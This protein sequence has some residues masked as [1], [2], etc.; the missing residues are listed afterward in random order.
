MLIFSN[1]D[2]RRFFQG[3]NVKIQLFRYRCVYIIGKFINLANFIII[4]Y[5][6]IFKIMTC[7]CAETRRAVY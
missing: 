3:K 1:K 7:D 5:L 4:E 6:F 2:W